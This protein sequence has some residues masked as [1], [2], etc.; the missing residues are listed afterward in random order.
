M[1]RGI[2]KRKPK[3]RFTQLQKIATGR[4][5]CI[6]VLKGMI[7]L[8]TVFDRY[9]VDKKRVESLRKT[10]A[11]FEWVIEKAWMDKKDQV[12]HEAPP[13]VDNVIEL[14]RRRG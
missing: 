10:L 12:L 9:G 5:W 11:S 1:P 8:C 7:G 4:N 13:E 6:Y 2:Y 14:K 3:S